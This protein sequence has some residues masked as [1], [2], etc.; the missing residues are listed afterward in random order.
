MP[1]KHT[2][3]LDL[4]P[5]KIV[6]MIKKEHA[7]R[8]S[9]QTAMMWC[10]NHN[11]ERLDNV[12]NLMDF[13][14]R[15]ACQL[16]THPDASKR[17]AKHKIYQALG[18]FLQHRCKTSS[19]P[20][21]WYNKEGYESIKTLC[22]IWADRIEA[23]ESVPFVLLNRANDQRAIYA[24]SS[25]EEEYA[26]KLSQ[27]AWSR[28]KEAFGFNEFTSNELVKTL[29]KSRL[30][31]VAHFF[32]ESEAIENEMIALFERVNIL[33]LEATKG[34]KA[35]DKQHLT[36]IAAYLHN[37]VVN[38]HP[39]EDGNGRY[40]RNLMDLLIQK[41][42][43]AVHRGIKAHNENAYDNAISEDFIQTTRRNDTQLSTE[44][45]IEYLD[46]HHVIVPANSLINNHVFA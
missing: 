10:K 3:I 23:A 18:A 43:Y 35:L 42:G 14:L 24:A 25:D 12:N 21:D 7:F 41:H 31:L 5:T 40:A 44:H 45:F 34:A 28:L 6:E 8:N 32:S 2:T 20:L 19:Y 30:E 29:T 4:A 15:I 37:G 39:F 9:D 22:A 27:E 11:Q 36:H 17:L 16:H 13:G 38:I 1:K 26:Q 46:K 33:L